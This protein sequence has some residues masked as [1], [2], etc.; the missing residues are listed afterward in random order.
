MKKFLI[1]AS[2]FLIPF[3][4]WAGIVM[5]IDPFNYFNVSSLIPDR[6]KLR[7]A[8]PLNRLMFNM[9]QY[10]H[11]PSD[12]LTIGDSRSY[13]LKIAQIEKIT[14]DDYFLLNSNALKL[15]ESFE[16]Y[17]FASRIKQPDK[18][19]FILNFNMFNKFAYADRVKG[20]EGILNNPLFYIFDRSVAETCWL[21]TKAYIQNSPAV[22]TTPPMTRE[23]FWDWNIQVKAND[24]YGKFS[25]PETLYDEMKRVVRHA[26]KNG[27]EI[28]FIIVPHHIEMQA[29]VAD[30]GLT[31][32]MN[33]FRKDLFELGVNVYDYDFVNEITIDR[34]NFDDPIHFTIATGDRIINEVWCG[35]MKIGRLLTSTVIDSLLLTDDPKH[36]D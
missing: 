9:I 36:G 14:G 18:V 25:Y 21:V 12:N 22:S 7:N 10:K 27:T 35:K 32:D 33:R 11:D 13:N 15:N 31:A 19:F 8:K 24:H 6:V 1:K 17:W 26:K 34:A 4:L 5:V 29:R 23:K 3:L 16:L 30:Y 20:A 28:T 2:I